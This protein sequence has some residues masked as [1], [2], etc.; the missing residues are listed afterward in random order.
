MFTQLCWKTISPNGWTEDIHSENTSKSKSA[1]ANVMCQCQKNCRRNGEGWGRW[2]RGR[3]NV[4]TGSSVKWVVSAGVVWS[5]RQ[6]VACEPGAELSETFWRQPSSYPV[7]PLT[8]ILLP[9]RKNSRAFVR[10]TLSLKIFKIYW[11]E[12]CQEQRTFSSPHVTL[13]V[14]FK[15][16]RPINILYL[17]SNFSLIS[18]QEN[19]FKNKLQTYYKNVFYP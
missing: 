17:K 10:K 4:N 14:D 9:L 7:G 3:G 2:F 11:I 6:S 18:G 19:G 15:I 12:N 8:Y 1:W 13:K 16:Q 5:L